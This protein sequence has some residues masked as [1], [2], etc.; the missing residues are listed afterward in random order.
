LLLAADSTIKIPFAD[1]SMSFFGFIVVAQF[2]AVCR[3]SNM[4]SMST[5]RPRKGWRLCKR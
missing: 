5:R 3:R 2:I 4:V 1:T